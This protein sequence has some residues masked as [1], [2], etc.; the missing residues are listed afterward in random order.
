MPVSYFCKALAVVKNSVAN[1]NS[2]W[3]KVQLDFTFITPGLS[4][5]LLNDKYHRA[6]AL[7]I[8]RTNI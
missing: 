4:L 2:L 7:N 1:Y 5:G 3:T 6:L 8:V